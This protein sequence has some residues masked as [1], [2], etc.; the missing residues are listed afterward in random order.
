M[1]MAFLALGLPLI[2][3]LIVVFERVRAGKAP[4]VGDRTHLHFRLQDAGGL[5]AFQSVIL[6]WS[7]SALFG[8]S[9][10]FVKTGGK[11]LLA[12]GVVMVTVALRTWCNSRKT[13]V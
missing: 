12:I 10:L 5:S 7:I 8:L 3:M 1:A 9:A 4:W 2:D 11:I 13:R 6:L